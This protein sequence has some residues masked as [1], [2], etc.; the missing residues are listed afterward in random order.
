MAL[1]WPPARTER[2]RG[3]VKRVRG[4]KTD[5]ATYVFVDELKSFLVK[6]KY[7]SYMLHR[8]FTHVAHETHFIVN[9]IRF[10]EE[11]L[12]SYRS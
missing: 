12:A 3:R 9:T 5:V 10:Y 1:W 4:Y 11:Q 2:A 6:A 7:G 8:K